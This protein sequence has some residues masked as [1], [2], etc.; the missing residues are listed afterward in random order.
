MIIKIQR[1][2]LTELFAAKDIHGQQRL[3]FAGKAIGRQL[4]SSDELTFDEARKVI[5]QLE[6]FSPDDP[7]ADGIPF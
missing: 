1:D 4:G 2:K 7:E 6:L 5:T 3:E